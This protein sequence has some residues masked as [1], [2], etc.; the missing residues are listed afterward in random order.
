MSGIADKMNKK[1]WLNGKMLCPDTDQANRGA[2][3]KGTTHRTMH[4]VPCCTP[5]ITP[6]LPEGA[7]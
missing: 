5:Y 7:V 3:M 6:T 2:P 1:K 4:A